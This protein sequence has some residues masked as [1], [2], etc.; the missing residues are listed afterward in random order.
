MDLEA[1]MSLG[2]LPVCLTATNSLSQADLRTVELLA[3]QHPIDSLS[4][5]SC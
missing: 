2:V 1:V 5:S 4:K 3:S